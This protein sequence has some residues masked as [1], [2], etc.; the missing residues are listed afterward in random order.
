MPFLQR[1]L[2]SV[3]ALNYDHD[4]GDKERMVGL[5]GLGLDA[6]G[7]VAVFAR[8]HVLPWILFS[9]SEASTPFDLWS[10]LFKSIIQML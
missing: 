4:I 10:N 2:T 1:L 6:F 9:K 3:V 7:T 5:G 8:M